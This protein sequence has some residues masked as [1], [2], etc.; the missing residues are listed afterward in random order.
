MFIVILVLIHKLDLE[1]KFSQVHIHKIR[2]RD[3]FLPPVR[4]VH[5]TIGFVN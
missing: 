5:N 1:S 2:V 3:D 4:F